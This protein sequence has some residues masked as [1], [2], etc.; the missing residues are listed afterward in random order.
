MTKA[1]GEHV[2]FYETEDHAITRAERGILISLVIIG[3]IACCGIA[4]ALMFPELMPWNLDLRPN[5]R[6]YESGESATDT[7]NRPSV[8]V[9]SRPPF[10]LRDG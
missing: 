9:D 4:F 3:I 2:G 6:P 5:L 8:G 1:T 10:H 7:S